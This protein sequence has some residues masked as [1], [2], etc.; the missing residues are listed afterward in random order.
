MRRQEYIELV[1]DWNSFL[2]KEE[3]RILNEQL[4]IESILLNE[5]KLKK[6][7]SKLGIPALVAKIALTAMTSG[8]SVSQAAPSGTDR[9]VVEQA[10]EL[11]QDTDF[12]KK[13]VEA[14]SYNSQNSIS[15]HSFNLNFDPGEL[16]DQTD[17]VDVTKEELRR[18]TEKLKEICKK[19]I[20][21]IVDNDATGAFAFL[22]Y[23]YSYSI[24]TNN[25][26]AGIKSAEKIID[27]TSNLFSK[28]LDNKK[29][30]NKISKFYK[31]YKKSWGNKIDAVS[32]A[33]GILLVC[34]YLREDCK[35]FLEKMALGKEKFTFAS[36]DTQV[37]T[38]KL[39]TREEEGEVKTSPLRLNQAY[40]KYSS[41]TSK[42]YIQAKGVF[43]NYLYF[44]K[45]SVEKENEDSIELFS[46]ELLDTRLL[47][48]LDLLI[49]D[50]GNLNNSNFNEMFKV[51]V[52]GEFIV[53]LSG[54][55]RVYINGKFVSGSLQKILT[56]NEKATGGITPDQAK[57]FVDHT[58]AKNS[59]FF[60]NEDY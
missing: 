51:F 16:F 45:E 57:G 58:H 48:I 36:L 26:R 52:M 21:D 13:A 32:R 49:D 54:E 22:N 29:I 18:L 40:E 47:K 24:G 46:S 17:V 43:L 37:V 12:R 53:V 1:N 42:Q 28:E 3:K 44:I 9:E 2:L 6:F 7:A 31:R 27:L 14:G 4:L 56:F 20:A 5:N 19:D 50:N 39:S 55:D 60:G 10:E 38:T 34:S 23:V 25:L 8:I 33:G 11:V 35:S 30:K 59:E 41:N 15:Y